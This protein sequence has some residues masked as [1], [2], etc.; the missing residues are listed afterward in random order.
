MN[1][2]D[3]KKKQTEPERLVIT[4]IWVTS[5]G[6]IANQY[7]IITQNAIWIIIQSFS[8]RFDNIS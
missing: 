6:P 8:H 1:V 2:I 7:I 5:L 3:R 4:C